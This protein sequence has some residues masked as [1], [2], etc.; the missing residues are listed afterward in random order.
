MSRGLRIQYPGAIYH[1]T[2]RGNRGGDIV[3][4]DQDRNDFGNVSE[5]RSFDSAGK[6]MPPRCSPTISISF[7]ARWTPT[8]RAACSET[9]LA[10]WQGEFGGQSPAERYRVLVE[11]S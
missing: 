6:C 5:K 8:C 1:V 10:A 3:I 2:S 9:L 7:S 11:G 4:D